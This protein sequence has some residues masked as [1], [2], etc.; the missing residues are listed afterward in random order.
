MSE[1]REWTSGI[2]VKCG[3]PV[4]LMIK[5]YLLKARKNEWDSFFWG[6]AYLIFGLISIAF[7]VRFPCLQKPPPF[8]SE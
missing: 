1:V 4:F 5:N 8:E 3:S 6:D 7:A 2:I